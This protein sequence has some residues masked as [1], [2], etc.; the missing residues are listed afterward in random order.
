MTIQN[1][2]AK[3]KG[4]KRPG[5]GANKPLAS[6]R[7]PSLVDLVMEGQKV[8]FL[9]KTDRGL[10]LKRS[11]VESGGQKLQP[12]GSEQIPFR[13]VKAKN[14]LKH[15]KEPDERLYRDIFNRLKSVA[16][17]PSEKH[18]HLVTV[19]VFFTYLPEAFSYYPYLWFFGLPERG[20][21]RIVKAVINL[22]YRGLY[23]ETL[24]QA[25]IF[26][27]A[28]RFSGTIGFDVYEL[29]EQAKKK[30]S[31]DLLLGRYEK[32]MKV[33]RVL[34][35]ER[36]GFEDT[37]YFEVSGP[38][39][40][41]TNVELPMRDPLRSRCIQIVMPEA[42]DKY[43]N[44]NAP[45]DLLDLRA[46]LTAFRARHLGEVLPEVEKPVAGRLGDITH[47]L[48]C[49]A[50]LLPPEAKEGL[51]TLIADLEDERKDNQSD[52]DAWRIV[53]ALYDLKDE[54]KNGRLP[55]AR[56]KEKVNMVKYEE[57][58]WEHLSV[59]LIGRELTALGIRR[60]KSTGTMWIIWD[61]GLM[62]RIWKRYGIPEQ[63]SP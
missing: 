10:K 60:K 41:A 59:Q 15:A 26:R 24:N 40:L 49:I 63:E 32:G 34:N 8:S 18:Y 20:K 39:V 50:T 54:V 28:D 3:Q 5:S 46:R 58:G 43:P 6:A 55:V 31:H 52:T 27:F 4:K 33:P 42:R 25:F 57:T 30:G 51:M 9:Y 62:E 22:A 35:H 47:P 21:S 61:R 1:A 29:S 44:N 13:L 17:L 11:H 19:Y 53:K 2:P 56:L 7:F 37:T 12:P 14:V 38:S 36:R 23:T 16:V 48:V 45:E